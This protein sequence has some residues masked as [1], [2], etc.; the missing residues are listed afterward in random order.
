MADLEISQDRLKQAVGWVGEKVSRLKLSEAVTGDPALKQLMEFEILSMGIEGKAL[1]WRSLEQVA[2]AYPALAKV[3]FA[4]LQKRAQAAA[5]RSGGAPPGSRPGCADR[6][7][8]HSSGVRRSAE[9]NRTNAAGQAVSA[10]AV[11][12]K[13][14]TVG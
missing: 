9:T 3:D 2:D 1:L 12:H 6:R 5:G 10:S 11:V 4:E 14:A 13:A 8:T 7:L